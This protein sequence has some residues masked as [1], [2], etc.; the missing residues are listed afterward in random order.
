MTPDLLTA[1][2]RLLLATSPHLQRLLDDLNPRGTL[3]VRELTLDAATTKALTLHC[4]VSRLDPAAALAWAEAHVEG[5]ALHVQAPTLHERAGTLWFG[6]V[7]VPG[8]PSA[9]LRLEL[10]YES[11]A[12]RAWIVLMSDVDLA[13]LE[14]LGATERARLAESTVERALRPVISQAEAFGFEAIALGVRESMRR[15][16]PSP[17]ASLLAHTVPVLMT[18][19]VDAWGQWLALIAPYLERVEADIELQYGEETFRFGRPD[20]SGL[21]LFGSQGDSMPVSPGDGA[22][23]GE[24]DDE[25]LER[26]CA[27]T[28]MVLGDAEEA[29]GFLD[30]ITALMRLLY[31]SHGVAELHFGRLRG[32]QGSAAR[33]STDPSR[34]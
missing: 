13:A 10:P 18:A 29:V 31:Q 20:V 1:R 15:L 2:Q 4:A 22:T 25:R 30:E 11:I 23:Y 19:W 24:E 6:K 32:A 12:R 27:V 5:A 17:A 28:G 9:Y 33:S 8:L 3:R 14:R 34:H 16:A 26:L 7:R 21:R